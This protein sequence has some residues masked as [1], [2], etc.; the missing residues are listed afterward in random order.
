MKDPRV[1]ELEKEVRRLR[2]ALQFY[3][4]PETYFAFVFFP[5]RP[6]GPFVE[7]FSETDLGYKPGKKARKILAAEVA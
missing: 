3:A 1:K 5:D 7:D 2:K 6:C 4:D